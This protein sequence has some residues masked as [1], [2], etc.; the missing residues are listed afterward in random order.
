[1]ASSAPT[2]DIGKPDLIWGTWGQ[3]LLTEWWETAPDLI[4]PQ[5]VITYGRMRHDPQITAVLS[6]Y[7]NPLLRATWVIDPEGCRDEVVKHVAD[8]LGVAVLGDDK[9]GSGPARRRG[10]IWQRHLSEAFNY[11]VFGH[12]PF[13]RR[14]E[15]QKDDYMRLIHLGCRMPWTIAQMHIKQDGTMDQIV[16]TTQIEPIPA[17][18]LVWYVNDLE[19]ANWAGISM[20]RAA[21]GAW[22]LKHETWRTHATSIRRFGM[23]VPTITAPP[24]ATQAQVI[25]AQQLASSI[26]AGDSSGMG[27]PPGFTATLQGITGSVPDALAFI[28]YLDIVIAKMV[29]AGLIELG[30]T[31]NGSRALGET[32]MD[33]FQLSLQGVADSIALTATSGHEGM[34]G[35]ITDLVDQNWGEDEPVPRLVCADVGENYELS[36]NALQSL[37]ISG[38]MTPDPALDEWVRE[39]WRLPKRTDKWTP[40][41]RGIPA[42][43]AIS[44]KTEQAQGYSGNVVPGAGPSGGGSGGATAPGTS[45]SGR[46][47]VVLRAA[48]PTRKQAA[49]LRASSF[50]PTQHQNDWEEALAHL[51]LQYRGIMSAQRT[52]L[53]DQV[54]N[55]MESG[56]SLVMASPSTGT[57]PSL[58]QAA[59]INVA[60]QA[61][62]QMVDEAARQGVTIDLENV[63]IDAERL[64][65]TAAA[66]AE[67]FS[68]WMAQQATAKALQVHGP[69]P[70]GYLAAADEV[71]SYLRNLSDVTLRDQLGA[72]LTTA[73]NAGRFAVMEAA[74][75]S[76]GQTVTYVASEFLDKNTC[77]HCRREDGTE[78]DNLGEATSAYP[79]GG[80]KDCEGLLRCRGTVVAVWGP[81]APEPG[82]GQYPYKNAQGQLT[83]AAG[84]AGPKVASVITGGGLRADFNPAEV[85]GPDG[86]WL[87]VG[88]ELKQLAHEVNPQ[89]GRVRAQTPSQFTHPDTGHK[90]GKTEIGDTFEALFAAKGAHLLEGRYGGAFKRI[91]GAGG[92]RNTPLDFQLDDTFGGELKTLNAAAT[93]QK[94]AIKKE[95]ITRKTDAVTA[96]KL[97]PLLV[98]QVVDPKNGRVEVYAHPAFASKMT[99]AMTHLGGY[100]F[101]PADFKAAQAAT[102]H[103]DQRT[104]RALEQGL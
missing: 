59:M 75:Q 69:T 29:H 26:R 37:T 25:Q 95:E 23:G 85:R 2:S 15:P 104:K 27:L 96:A 6:A 48:G 17:E 53:V 63:R 50:E 5:S 83:Y 30:Q 89:T 80:Y 4:W 98:V 86:K 81:G 3:G 88:G 47:S 77:D 57:G 87:K 43:A 13:E 32:F 61:A 28:K 56:G 73:Q 103:W 101:G 44:P 91:S 16:Q 24:G 21:F 52:A 74:P 39:T 1:M 18:R 97:K 65:G 12:M 78:F 42:G 11:L 82:S 55:A 90:M 20:L 14:Y 34:P 40:S 64:G 7:K 36:A 99:T 33:M 22:L 100:S 66:R 31:D 84:D 62:Q 92:P 71:D 93:N 70:E 79:T 41:S 45:A 60:R 19:G 68:G 9:I 102:G 10:V 54:I 49:Y 67:F 72:A 8:D 46:D 35:I 58:V 51:L 38:A 76:A 94:T